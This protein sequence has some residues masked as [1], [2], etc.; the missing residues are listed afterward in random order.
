MVWPAEEADSE[1]LFSFVMDCCI[2]Y[3]AFLFW[4]LL[5]D[6][7]L[8]SVSFSQSKALTSLSSAWW[9]HSGATMV[10]VQ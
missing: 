7:A 3:L 8:N 9:N 2:Y 5:V 4:S 6:F 10:C 1:V